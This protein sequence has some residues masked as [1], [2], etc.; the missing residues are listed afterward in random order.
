MACKIEVEMIVMVSIGKRA[1]HRRERIAA[2]PM[3]GPKE[4][5][6]AWIAPPAT[7]H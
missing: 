2:A 5:A 6:L 7:A 3:H 1:Q 4:R